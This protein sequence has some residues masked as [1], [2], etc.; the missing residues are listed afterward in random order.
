MQVFKVILSFG[1]FEDEVLA[2]PYTVE[3]TWLIR[4]PRTDRSDRAD[5]PP[6]LG[7]TMTFVLPSSR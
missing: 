4:C 3:I 6:L 5:R 2:F 1:D 7:S